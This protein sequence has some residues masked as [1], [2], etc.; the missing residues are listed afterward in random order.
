MQHRVQ[1]L[2]SNYGAMS[3]RNAEICI[4][5]G[6]VKVNNKVIKIGDKA[7]ETD[8]I[9]IDDTPINK[10][11]RVYYMFNK[12]IGCVTALSDKQ[13]RTIMHYI[14]IKE[15]VIPVGRLDHDTSG[16]LI[17]TN[18]GDFANS[19]MHPRYEI[20][21]TYRVEV[22]AGI[23]DTDLREIEKGVKLEE[24]KTYPAT[25]YRIASNVVEIIIHEGKRRI[26]RRMFKEL[27]YNVLSLSRIKVGNLELGDLPEGEYRPLT[28]EEK[29]K[30]FEKN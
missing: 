24:G 27:G 15:R 3:R 5:Q 8:I 29:K 14:H 11:S 2:I 19:I 9:S 1:K 20:K 18:D 12:P 10:E 17:L 21:K 4:Q 13:F 26:I 30:I 16:L 28:E 22:D 23:S 6:R 25:T 7:T